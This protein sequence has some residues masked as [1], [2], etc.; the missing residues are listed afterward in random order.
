MRVNYFYFRKSSFIFVFI[1]FLQ[2]QSI[3]S[4]ENK[5]DSTK[6]SELWNSAIK[7]NKNRN[8]YAALEDYSKALIIAP[9]NLSLIHI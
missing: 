7:H 1:F 3:Q 2:F 8:H 4:S 5:S 6:L 9:N